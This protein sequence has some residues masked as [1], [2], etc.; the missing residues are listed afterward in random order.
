MPLFPTSGNSG[1]S[2]SERR[3][4]FSSDAHVQASD[5]HIYAATDN[6]HLV[7]IKL[8]DLFNPPLITEQYTN[9]FGHDI[10][11][12]PATLYKHIERQ[13]VKIEP[14]AKRDYEE[15]I[16]FRDVPLG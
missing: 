5:A 12:R 15:P 10:G 9:Q 3:R 8:A 14:V 16:A 7:M 6:G 13:I 2:A 4:Q 1:V 11:D